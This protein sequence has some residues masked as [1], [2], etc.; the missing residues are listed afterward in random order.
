M[1]RGV[2]SGVH[3][4][5]SLQQ[6]G[7]QLLRIQV[8]INPL[9]GADDLLPHLCECALYVILRPSLTP[10]RSN[11]ARARHAPSF[12][13][14]GIPFRW[15]M[16]AGVHPQVWFS[17]AVRLPKPEH[18]HGAQALAHGKISSKTC[19]C[20]SKFQRLFLSL[21]P[22]DVSNTG[23]GVVGVRGVGG[24]RA[25]V[26]Q[27]PYVQCLPPIHHNHSYDWRVPALWQT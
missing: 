19:I 27:C 26:P 6:G 20:P 21:T 1:C 16:C 12:S 3:H 25:E 7:V 15:N 10:R 22:H 24:D 23:D 4:N 2:W 17:P 9:R 13:T 5:N 8:S 14:E 11:L 18:R